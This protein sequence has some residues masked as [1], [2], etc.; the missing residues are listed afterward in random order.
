MKKISSLEKFGIVC[1][2]ILVFVMVCSIARGISNAEIQWNQ[3]SDPTVAGYNLYYG[4]A[5]RAYTNMTTVGNTNTT[6]VGGLLEGKTYFFAVTAYDGDGFESTFSDE[7]IYVVPGFL[8]LTPGTNPG[9]PVRLQFP[10]APAH[11]YELQVS[12]D[13]RSWTTI[14][15]TV[16]VSNNWVEFDAPV[17]ATGAQFYRLVL[18]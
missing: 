18:H 11:W 2:V 17:A 16:G 6:T 12:G 4:G 5:S 10:V 8:V 9:D 15:Q 3:N 14:W 1:G 13:L 7:T